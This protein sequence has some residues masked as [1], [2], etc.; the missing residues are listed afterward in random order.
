MEKGRAV[1]AGSS[2]AMFGGG[3]HSGEVSF[4]FLSL[5]NFSSVL[6]SG[7]TFFGSG[8]YFPIA[9]VSG[10]GSRVPIRILFRILHD[11][12]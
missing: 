11:F 5:L 12:F 3:T 4:V 8:S 1:A 2:D 10:S 9:S 7:M 6:G